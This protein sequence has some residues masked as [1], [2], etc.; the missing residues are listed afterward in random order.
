MSGKT[1]HKGFDLFQTMTGTRDSFME[2]FARIVLSL[3]STGAYQRANAAFAKPALLATAVLREK[4]EAA[5]S[6]LLA[7][8]NIPSRDELLALSQ[9]LTRIEMTLDDLGA[10]MDQLR[11]GAATPE[12]PATREPTNGRPTATRP[13]AEEG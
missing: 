6:E 5:M 7:F 4:R 11:R 1:E 8:F 13:T 9:R 3:T 10:G 12:R 2:D